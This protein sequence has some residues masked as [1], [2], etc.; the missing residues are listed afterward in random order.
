M[1]VWLWG[2]NLWVFSQG[3]VNYTKVFDLDQNHL[4][5]KEIWKVLSF[6][7]HINFIYLWCFNLL[8]FLVISLSHFLSYFT[9][10]TIPYWGKKF[11]F[12]FGICSVALGWQLLSPLAW[13][14]TFIS[15]LMEKYY[16]R[17][18]NQC[19]ICSV[20]WSTPTFAV[21]G[22]WFLA[23]DTS[24]QHTAIIMLLVSLLVSSIL[25][26]CCNARC[27]CLFA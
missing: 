5:H 19:N 11:N 8:T 25:N 17:H 20:S 21:L 15:T 14:H 10:F 18:H 13:Q 2:V 26:K 22:F 23:S 3:S 12:W 7:F 1:M 6:A 24:F 27:G 4:T 9:E 16:W